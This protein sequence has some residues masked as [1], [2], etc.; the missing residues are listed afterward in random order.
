G[1][2]TPDQL[3]VIRDYGLSLVVNSSRSLE[4]LLGA[5]VSKSPIPDTVEMVSSMQRRGFAPRKLG[6]VIRKLRES[7]N[8]IVNGLMIHLPS[9]MDDEEGTMKDLSGFDKKV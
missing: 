4:Q 3:K 8:A 6:S 9:P 1:P 5:R 2:A 7:K